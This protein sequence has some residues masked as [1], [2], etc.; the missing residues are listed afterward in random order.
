MRPDS[1]EKASLV[2]RVWRAD[3]SAPSIVIIRDGEMIDV[4]N[5]VIS[6]SDFLGNDLEARFDGLQ[7]EKL[8]R[9]DDFVLS[10]YET[11]H[12]SRHHSWLAPSD[13]QVLKACGVTFVQNMIERVIDERTSG[14]R[15]R[16]WLHPQGR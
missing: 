15:K 11:G 16:Q 9:P 8:G 4:T 6:V 7:G 10:P 12:G 1:H 3:L 5:S 13:F 2:G 14:P